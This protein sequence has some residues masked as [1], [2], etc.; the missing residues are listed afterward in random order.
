MAITVIILPLLSALICFIG[1][2]FLPKKSVIAVSITSMM[3]SAICSIFI[4]TKLAEPYHANISTWIELSDFTLNW[5]IYLDNL[6]A[7]MLCIVTIISA[8]VHIYSIGYMEKDPNFNRFMGYLSLFTFFML[9]LVSADNFLQM[10]LGWEGV[11][12]CSY[13]LIGFWYN[14]KSACKAADLAL[15]VNRIADCALLFGILLIAYYSKSLNFIDVFSNPEYLINSGFN[16][17]V[18]CCSFN[19]IDV[20]CFL[21]F[22]GC[23]GKSAQIFFHVWLPEAM[24]GPTP[25]SALIHAATMVTA[26]VFLLIRCAPLFY[27]SPLVLD[28][29]CNIGLIT[30]LFGALVA[31]VQD[32]IKKIIAYST[33]SQLGYMFIACGISAYHAAIFHLCTH[34]FFKAL[35]FLAAGNI[36]HI[37]H[38]QDVKMMG[39]LRKK[40]PYTF[41]LFIIGSCAIMGVYPFAG[42][43]SKESIIHTAYYKGYMKEFYISSF[44]AYL[45]AFYSMKIFYKVFFGPPKKTFETTHEASKIML[46]PLIVLVIGSIISGYLGEHYLHLGEDNR[47]IID[48]VGQ[49]NLGDVARVE[50]PFIIEFLPILM[51]A[52]GCL[53]SL[54]IY[55]NGIE[56]IFEHNFF[57][58]MIQS[59]FY[60]P[61]FYRIFVIKPYKIFAK[62]I[63]LFDKN[64]VD[65]YGPGGMQKL[66]L[67]AS[68]YLRHIHGG[69]IINYV[70]FT[71]IAII[72]LFSAIIIY[73]YTTPVFHLDL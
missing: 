24:E 39:G 3:V 35:L 8:V 56:K 26:G 55:A 5:A 6:S 19:L 54:I 20:I 23:M 1:Q 67:L 2:K 27:F 15:I 70:L 37:T 60:I 45:T 10:F 50:L 22:I 43:Y 30:C 18:C 68:K 12:V 73:F 59:Q 61:C 33:C 71:V 34:A 9:M 40:L 38:V 7:M 29:I 31:I 14:K 16:L 32:D 63:T 13:L 41:L 52:A 58:K 51:C 46:L 65:N 49:M 53:S 25:V 69:Y 72:A 21:L 42:F 44:V 48:A 47:Y 57:I 28:F 62:F 66:F 4:Y 17:Q 64:I 36:I 11:G